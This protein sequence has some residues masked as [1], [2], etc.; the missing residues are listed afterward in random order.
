MLSFQVK[1]IRNAATS[2]R[3]YLSQDNYYTTGQLN[4]QWVGIG[5]ERLNLVGEV[6]VEAL[7]SVLGGVLPNG[8]VI[9]LK[10]K[11]GEIIHRGGYDLTF[12]APKSLSY[13]AL[14]SGHTQF[15]DIHVNA[16]KKV[17]GWIE[18]EAAC[19]RKSIKGEMSYE[20][21]GNLCFATV[22]HDMSREQD[23]QL[24]IHAL[25]MNATQRDD[26]EWRALASDL[27]RNHGTM[28]WIMDNQIFLG[29]MYRAEVAMGLK[30][31]GL[32]VEH[33]GDAHGLFEIKHFDKALLESISK[34]RANIKERVNEMR[35]DS[36]KAYD[37]AT[38]ETRKAKQDT[39]PKAV[40]EQWKKDSLS[41]GVNP[42]TYFV[43]LKEKTHSFKQSSLQ[44]CEK[45]ATYGINEAI[46]HL[47]ERH[48]A[49]S[50]QEILQSA[51]YFS[52]GH[53][54]VDALIEQIESQISQ[55]RLIALDEDNTQFTTTSLIDKERTLV[56]KLCQYGLQ[57]KAIARDATAVC[58]LTD[59]ESIQKVVLAA[60]FQKEG[61]VR[62]KQD[63]A[64]SRELLHT[65]MAYAQDSKTVRV[66]SP[67]NS[68][69]RGINQDSTKSPQNIW[70]WL[71]A[72][73]KSDVAQTVAGFNHHHEHDHKLPFFKSRTEHELLI[74]DESQ[75]LSPD[76]LS[77]LITIA[78]RRG[79]KLIFL[80]KKES[81]TGFSSDVPGLLDKAHVKTFDVQDRPKP[82][83]QINL[84]EI[85]QKEARILKT[86][87]HYSSLT[88]KMRQNTQTLTVSKAEALEVNQA[89]RVKLKEQGE[90]SIDEKFIPT[91]SR[92]NL[93]ESEKKLAKSYQPDWVLIRSGRGEF[94]QLTVVGVYE[95][96]NRLRVRDTNGLTSNLS[97]N[98][99]GKSTQV[100][101]QTPLA[102][103]IG[104]RLKAC[105]NLPFEGIKAGATYEVSA[106]TR[107]GVMLKQGTKK[108]QIIINPNKHMPLAHAYA[109]SIY[110]HDF[111]ST[112]N[113]LLTL[114]AYALRKNILSL[115]SESSR[116]QLTVITDDAKKAEHYAQ[117]LGTATSAIALTL[118]SANTHHGLEVIDNKTTTHLLETLDKALELLTAE[119][120]LKSESEKALNFAIAHLSEREAA[121]KKSKVLE[122]ALEKAIGRCDVDALHAALNHAM[123]DWVLISGREG[124]LTTKEAIGFEERIINTVKCGVN[125]I[126]PFLTQEQS[127]EKLKEARLTQGQKEACQLITTTSDRFIMIQGYAGTGKTTMTKT[128]IDTIEYVTKNMIEGG[129]DI[130]AVAPTHQAVKEMK[131]LGIKAQTLKSFLI[132]QNQEPSITSRSIVL[133]DESSMVS[134]RDGANL[135]Q[136][137]H[138]SGAR[139]VLLGDISQHQ[140]I[141]SGKPTK[142]LMQEGSIQVACMD[143]LVRQQVLGYKKAVE[144]LISG[145][146]DKALS[147]FAALPQAGIERT[148]LNSPYLSLNTSVMESIV[149]DEHTGHATGRISLHDK[150]SSTNPLESFVG[151]TP[152]Q[153][154]VGDYLSRTS[155][156]RDNTIVIIHENKK[157]EVANQMIRSALMEEVSLGM[158]NKEFPRL[159]S[160]NYTTAEL[161]FCETYRDCIEKSG[162]FF[163][164]KENQYYKVMEVDTESK[165]VGLQND[166]GEKT[167]FL[168]EKES[169]NWKIELFESAPAKISVGERIHFK[170]SDKT[171]GRFANERVKVMKVGE[172][173]FTVKDATGLEHVLSQK[174]MKDAH[175]DYSYTA[176]SYSI[177]GASSPFV[178]GVATTGNEYLNHFRS[179]YIMVTRGSLH[180]MVYTDDLKKLGKQIKITPDKTSA[181]EAVG[182]IGSE[183]KTKNYAPLNASNHDGLTLKDTQSNDLKKGD[184]TLKVRETS[185]YTPSHYPSNF[186]RKQSAKTYDAKEIS[187]HLNAN[188]EQVI[189][190]LLGEPNRSLSS[191]NEYRYGRNGSLSLCLA[192]EKRG[193]WFNFETLEK[194]NLLHLIQNTLHLNFK[195]SLQYAAQ[196]T[197]D[198]LKESIKLSAQNYNIIKD[199]PPKEKKGTQDLAKRLAQESK[200]IQ[201]TL[202]ERYLKETRAID[203]VSC[204]NLRFHPAAYTNRSEEVKH[205]PA[206]LNI[207]RNKDNKLVAVEVVYLDENTADKAIMQMKPKKSY[208]SKSDAAVIL[209]PGRDQNSVTYITEGVETG[210]SIRDAV[211]NERV[212]V[213]LGK[214]NF[215]T[216]N[217]DMLT[218]KVVLCLDNDGK[219]IKDDPVIVKTIE[220]LIQH[221][222]SVEIALPERVKDFNDVK[223]LN[224]TLGVIDALNKS[225]NISKIDGIPSQLNINQEQIKQCIER[226]SKQLNLDIPQPKSP[227]ISTEKVKTIQRTEMEIC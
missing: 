37:R 209:N 76:A 98:T 111:K 29:L 87:E 17:L 91:L 194:G 182:R 219:P 25:L 11:S 18:R 118:D 21:T 5:A 178:I 129:A 169:K 123:A 8:C 188:A 140:A 154:A 121:F 180:A 49:F 77:Q 46:A 48:L 42:E 38:L 54:G 92:C 217:M 108:I 107:H 15:T 51:L 168:P 211:K 221:G 208:G 226:M 34:R 20:K 89:I 23:A 40:R 179:F 172:D 63:S 102:V 9:G 153:M 64:T 220:R 19:A 61:V 14:V 122:V 126:E 144:T 79:A 184:E 198:D 176:T 43:E 192:G 82:T 73:G 16:V 136:A 227:E 95:K 195:E 70:Q 85:I 4:S 200:P 57:K 109:N 115:V 80:E 103:S 75:R 224:G 13:L 28:E 193:T 74:V 214:Q 137:I 66:L 27:S 36:L 69:A 114:P 181:L 131:A 186:N 100:Y 124:L 106:F 6:G 10:S 150:A 24:H 156:V 222:K 53:Q 127:F 55:G 56:S 125:T 58:K 171:Q 104:E 22:L 83:T 185:S 59:N 203:N 93:T 78:D 174:D 145:D 128:A 101:E 161:Y 84:V 1:P 130:I 170:K 149:G 143:N 117:K 210:L 167:L 112:D 206:L 183:I 2:A 197:G 135:I 189:E 120:P 223:R 158:E 7:K 132:E 86:A 146:T 133:L 39:N 212:L 65:L 33:T 148:N 151:K 35:S 88:P 204:E 90:I 139:G 47:E 160:T 96:E 191:K 162:E 31:L 138:N 68:G 105:A 97:A 26:G 196:L 113:T 177:Q 50:Y 99:V 201:G 199:N 202:A 216:L 190:S 62:I 155:E 142:L 147:Q 213:T 60:L 3:Y 45:E 159:V 119:K 165:V 218:N 157:R 32:E 110:T 173:S 71:M 225:N 166:K 30:G 44:A 175:W 164:K 116:D 72:I 152:I 187:T 67:T 52:Q 205:R 41:L 207:M 94:K 81:L 12:S 163:L 215:S 141:E 134:N